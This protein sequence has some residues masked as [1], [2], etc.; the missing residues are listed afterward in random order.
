M[1]D[2]LKE[3]SVML[4]RISG[5]V[6]TSLLLIAMSSA[7]LAQDMA[8]AHALHV[9][10]GSG[11]SGDLITTWRPE[12]L[13]AGNWTAS[14]L[15]EYAEWSLVRWLRDEQDARTADQ[16]ETPVDQL[17]VLNLGASYALHQRVGVGM[18]LPVWVV[19]VLADG[20]TTPGVGDI[21]LSVPVGIAL[22]DRDR[23]GW[24]FSAIPHVQIPSGDEEVGLGAPGA[25][26]GN[27]L[28]LAY[29][30]GAW[31][32]AMNLG[33]ATG[34]GEA[35][36]PRGGGGLGSTVHIHDALGLGLELTT[37]L[38]LNDKAGVA[39]SEALLSGRGQLNERLNWTLGAARSLS[40]GTFTPLYRLFAGVTLIGPAAPPPPEPPV[41]REGTVRVIT[42]TIDG[43]PVNSQVRFLGEDVRP[44]LDL[45]SDGR[46]EYTL[47]AGTWRVL[48][49]APSLGRTMQEI[50]LEPGRSD[51]YII[52]VI[53]QPG[54]VEVTDHEIQIKE[55]IHFGFDQATIEPVSIGLLR[56]VAA[57]M[58]AEEWIQEIEVQGHTDSSGE[59]DYNLELSQRRVEAVRDALIGF[60]VQPDRLEAKGY[61]EIQPIASNEE[62]AGRAQNRRVQFIIIQT[63][64]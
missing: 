6:T 45:G 2:G 5:L 42:R 18:T 35:A 61:G 13:E 30:Q 64:E 58:L 22:P 39:A 23:S 60:G 52:E 47:P 63:A 53:L 1:M 9:I 40:P 12:T 19:P 50:T 34:F 10:P 21:R 51:V 46:G 37:A 31:S 56:E 26:T 7:G 15:Y 3:P 57:T 16:L 4:L 25:R 49:T 43:Q 62:D 38:P 54:R 27:A 55:K 28:A 24:G 11:G 14:G 8:D 17:N 29:G 44:P 59:P 36:A 20:T 33:V 48:I 41:V 32:L